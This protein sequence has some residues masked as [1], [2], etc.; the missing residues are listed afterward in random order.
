MDNKKEVICFKQKRDFGEI[1]G[2]PFYFI[3]QEYKPFFSALFRYTYPYLFLLFVSF[4]MLSDDIYEMSAE[5]PRFSA[6]STVYFSFFLAALVLCFLIVVTVTYSYIAMYVKKGK[7]GFVA[8]EVGELYKKNVLNVFIAGF[9]VWISVLAGLLL[10][11]IP[12]IYLSTA[13]SFVFIILVYENKTI[14]E[15]FSGTFEIIKGN[16]WY[17][18][19][20]I[21]VFGLIAGLM[22]YVVLI[23][24]YLVV[25]TTFAGGGEFGYI[26]FVIL[27]FLVFLYFAIYLFIVSMQQIMLSFLYFTLKEKK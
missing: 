24:I 1:L 22:S 20:L 7:D 17:T 5:Q 26:S 23:P 27:S 2:A 15:A 6:L 21:F 19:A 4:A 10:L 14:G 8:E 11:Y 18:F 12:G 16:W 13:L 3:I 25:L 9:L